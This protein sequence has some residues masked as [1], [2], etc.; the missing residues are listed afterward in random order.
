MKSVLKGLAIIGV[1]FLLVIAYFGFQKIMEAK[2]IE[3]IKKGWYVEVV[4]SKKPINVRTKPSTKGKSIGTVSVGEVYKALEVDTSNSSYYWYKIEYGDKT[5]WVA[6]GPK[7]AWLK[8]N[9]NPTD[10]ATPIIKFK[11]NIYKVATINDINYKHLIV[12]EDTD[13]YKITHEIFHEVKPS[14]FIDQYWIQ[15]TVTDGS[16]KSS[17]KVQKIEFEV[18]PEES[19][20]KDFS[21][22]KR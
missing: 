20:I 9:N 12:E 19:Q 2:R 4:Y 18:R 6:A 11:D 13:V 21:E 14:E 5:G 1:I 7:R 8:D 10:I 17:S 15:Y 22:M 3:D 16:G